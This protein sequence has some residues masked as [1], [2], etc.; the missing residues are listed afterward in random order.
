ML[1][2]IILAVCAVL[3]I[4]AASYQLWSANSPETNQTSAELWWWMMPM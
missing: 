3:S 4:A 2:L 1:E